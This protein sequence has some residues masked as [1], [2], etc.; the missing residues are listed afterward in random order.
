MERVLEYVIAPGVSACGYRA[1]TALEISETGE[2]TL[3]I[4]NYLR[5]SPWVIA[6]LTGSNPNVFY[7]LAIRHVVGKP[8]IQ[9]KHP[10]ER[11]PFDISTIRTIDL[12]AEDLRSAHQA[13]D[14]IKTYIQQYD[15]NPTPIITPVSRAVDFASIQSTGTPEERERA[16]VNARLSD[17]ES[18]LARLTAENSRASGRQQALNDI[19][20]GQHVSTARDVQRLFPAPVGEPQTF[21]AFDALQRAFAELQQPADKLASRKSPKKPNKS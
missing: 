12:D 5:D 17:I 1:V 15:G 18:Q 8:F 11:L 21:S 14:L 2:I 10:T 20:L 9:I 16:E 3:Q 7:E 4:I 19:L 13:I 6:D